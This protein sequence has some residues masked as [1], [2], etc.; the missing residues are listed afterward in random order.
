[1]ADEVARAFLGDLQLLDLAEVTLQVLGGGEGGTDHHRDGGRAH[2]QGT[3]LGRAGAFAAGRHGRA[4]D[5]SYRAIARAVTRA[6]RGA[7]IGG[8]GHGAISPSR[9]P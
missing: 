7:T 2:R 9:V 5:A 1:M 6:I 4:S 8:D 3:A